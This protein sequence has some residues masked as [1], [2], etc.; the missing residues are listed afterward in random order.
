[1]LVANKIQFELILINPFPCFPELLSVVL[2]EMTLPFSNLYYQAVIHR[3][4]T[5]TEGAVKT[6]PLYVDSIYHNKGLPI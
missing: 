2:A 4:I 1:M 5:N 6:A 3:R